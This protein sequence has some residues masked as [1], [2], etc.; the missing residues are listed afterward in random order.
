MPSLAAYVRHAD[1]YGGLRDCWEAAADELGA[2]ELGELAAALRGL[3]ARQRRIGRKGRTVNV[4]T[5]RLSRDETAT[6]IARLIEAGTADVDV[7]RYTG[8][9]QSMVGAIRADRG[10][11][12][13][14][15][16]ELEPAPQAIIRNASRSPMDR[17]RSTVGAVRPPETRTCEWC[18]APLP[19]TLRGDARYCIGGRCKFGRAR[20]QTLSR[21][22]GTALLQRPTTT[23]SQPGRQAVNCRHTLRGREPGRSFPVRQSP[24]LHAGSRRV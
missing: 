8:A 13:H 11:D 5:F 21:Y 2:V 17:P 23:D 4:E 6:L 19:A 9:A 16:A 7:C 14:I 1:A 3:A 24:D 20:G 22:P 15:S 10:P 18:S 12:P